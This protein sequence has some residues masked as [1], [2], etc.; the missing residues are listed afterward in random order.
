[1]NVVYETAPFGDEKQ[2][3]VYLRAEEGSF[4]TVAVSLPRHSNRVHCHSASCRHS[5]TFVV[6]TGACRIDNLDSYTVDVIRRMLRAR[7]GGTLLPHF[8]VHLNHH[9]DAVLAFDERQG[10]AEQIIYHIEDIFGLPHRKRRSP[11]CVARMTNIRRLTFNSTKHLHASLLSTIDRFGDCPRI[12][13]IAFR[14]YVIGAIPP[15]KP[16][17]ML[18]VVRKSTR[19]AVPILRYNPRGPRKS[20]QK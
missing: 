16:V 11:E 19:K 4:E 15:S 3:W 1:M 8:G 9:T 7:T 6:A 20:I 13:D 14:V 5:I 10:L 18:A 17:A 2:N 12:A